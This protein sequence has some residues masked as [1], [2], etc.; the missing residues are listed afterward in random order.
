MFP[1]TRN[2]FP[3]NQ[4]VQNNGPYLKCLSMSTTTRFSTFQSL[5]RPR[6]VDS[7]A[8]S[9]LVICG[10]SCC[11]HG[12]LVGP[13]AF[14]DELCPLMEEAVRVRDERG[15]AVPKRIHEVKFFRRLDA[16]VAG[17]HASDSVV[18]AVVV[19]WALPLPSR[20]RHWRAS[21]PRVRQDV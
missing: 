5:L 2:A 15:R 4:K 14:S 21:L 3:S 11:G 10:M 6:R 18:I 8:S 7:Q 16:S 13:P 9:S 20:R 1:R 19:G 17:M 12:A